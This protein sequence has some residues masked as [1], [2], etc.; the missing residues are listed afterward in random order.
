MVICPPGPELCRGVVESGLI[1]LDHRERRFTLLCVRLVGYA[2][3]RP[4]DQAPDGHGQVTTAREGTDK[5]AES[6]ACIGVG[7]GERVEEVKEHW[8]GESA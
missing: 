5:V 2:V 3:G 7:T 1:L 6:A 8:L 4:E